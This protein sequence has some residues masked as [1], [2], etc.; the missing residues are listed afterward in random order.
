MSR[1]RPDRPPAWP[2]GRPAAPGGPGSNCAAPPPGVPCPCAAR[3]GDAPAVSRR[4]CTRAAAS[5]VG[6][7]LCLSLESS[8]SRAIERASA[9]CAGC[10]EG[11][12]SPRRTFAARNS[13]TDGRV[14]KKTERVFATISTSVG[15]SSSP[16][17]TLA[18]RSSVTEGRLPRKECKTA[19]DLPLCSAMLERSERF[20]TGP[21][22]PH[23]PPNSLFSHSSLLTE[24]SRSRGATEPTGPL[25]QCAAYAESLSCVSTMARSADA[26]AGPSERS[27]SCT[28]FPLSLPPPPPPPRPPSLWA[29]DACF[30]EAAAV[31]FW[32]D[33]AI[34]RSE[35]AG[36]RRM[37]PARTA[38]TKSEASSSFSGTQPTV[39][40]PR[41]GEGEE[42][43]RTPNEAPATFPLPPVAATSHLPSEDKRRG[44]GGRTARLVP[45][46]A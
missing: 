24:A 23:S 34:A 15:S 14:S 28:P 31:A 10:S 19:S 37:N 44:V 6:E 29:D 41:E 21:P 42:P 9:S 39:G 26:S 12:A 18:P 30:K 40:D 22:G 4:S 25:A 35:S 46:L 7:G 38:P 43:G 1:Q 5:C 11:A 2:P 17:S 36:G 33:A 45:G 3:S 27:V 8:R 16:R 32:M 20:P 13:G